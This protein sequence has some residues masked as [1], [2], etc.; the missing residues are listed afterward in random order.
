[1]RTVTFVKIDEAINNSKLSKQVRELYECGDN[2]HSLVTV[3]T[4]IATI[5]DLQEEESFDHDQCESA[6]KCLKGVQS[7]ILIDMEE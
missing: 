4:V 3:N 2:L 7:G 1:M 6:L 5:Q